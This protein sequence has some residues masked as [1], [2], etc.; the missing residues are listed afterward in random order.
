MQLTI[1]LPSAGNFHHFQ[2]VLTKFVLLAATMA[3]P[4]EKIWKKKLFTG[5][6]FIIHSFVF[7]YSLVCGFLFTYLT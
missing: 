1:M 7:S 4:S 6:G 3:P 2:F 5:L